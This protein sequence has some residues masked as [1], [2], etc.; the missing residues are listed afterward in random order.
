L[1]GDAA[2]SGYFDIIAP[3]AASA[4]FYADAAAADYFDV[5][6]PVF[7]MQTRHFR[8]D[9]DPSRQRFSSMLNNA[10]HAL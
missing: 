3:D 2:F 7:T 6:P 8:Y 5:L 4:A 9:I 1:S 10:R